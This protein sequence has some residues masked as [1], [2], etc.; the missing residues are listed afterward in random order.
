MRRTKASLG[1]TIKKIASY[2]MLV[3]IIVSTVF[4]I[5]YT[6]FGNSLIGAVLFAIG[7]LASW[8]F[9]K[10]LDSYGDLVLHTAETAD[11]LERIAAQYPEMAAETDPKPAAPSP[12]KPSSKSFWRCAKC[13]Y[14]NDVSVSVCECCGEPRS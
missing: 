2:L 10:L 5:A 11:Y 14:A 4:F 3:G 9:A 6:V 12:S 8:L 7:C 1:P 13:G